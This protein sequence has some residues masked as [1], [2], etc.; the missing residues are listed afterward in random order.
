MDRAD[1][2]AGSAFRAV[3]R[4]ALVFVILLA[5]GAFFTVRYLEATL[6]DEAR[7]R[8]IELHRGILAVDAV[9][10]ES[11]LIAH[12]SNLIRTAA[13]QT[14]AY[15]LYRVDGTLLA[16]NIDVPLA[17]GAW[18]VRT[19]EIAGDRAGPEEYLLHASLVGKN[20]FVSGRNLGF[21]ETASLTMIRGFAVDGFLIVIAMIGIGY[22]LSRG[23]QQ[24]LETIEQ[25]LKRVAEGDATARIGIGRGR[26]QIDRIS[27][28]LDAQLARLDA[29]LQGTRRTTAAVAHD[30]RRPLA[31]VSLKLERGLA[32]AEAGADVRA[33]LEEGLEGLGKLNAIIATILRISRIESHDI[34][35]FRRF[36][37]REVLDEVAEVY[38]A[39][40]EDAGQR[41]I[42][43]R[44]TEA[45]D[46]VGDADMIAQ[47]AINLVQN[48]ITH[49]GNGATITLAAARTGQGVAL[50]VADTG[51]GIP[52]EQR[53]RVFEPTYRADAARTTDGNGLGLALVKAIAERHGAE[54]AL[55]DN[56]PGLLVRV[57][58]P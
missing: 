29:T 55:Q 35:H 36:D 20:L 13:G 30:L 53:D 9:D 54:I 26:D 28:K 12:V 41:L 39:V 57:V 11:Q 23:S 7:K 10:D 8:V 4:S 46:M 1:I 32:K 2:L 16:G 56:R 6:M 47:L 48:A 19:L 18:E 42:Y 44:P 49:A 31:R 3:L 15:A 43:Q 50:T 27:Q 14:L 51:A 24:K 40:A 33:D 21:V 52:A 58:F 37:L 34:G 5:A 45:V 25:V 38:P 17:P 22:L